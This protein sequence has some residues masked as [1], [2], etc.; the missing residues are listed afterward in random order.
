MCV[1]ISVSVRTFV[2]T[3]VKGIAFCSFIKLCHGPKPK[4]EGSFESEILSDAR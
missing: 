2:S 4:C 1:T 3:C